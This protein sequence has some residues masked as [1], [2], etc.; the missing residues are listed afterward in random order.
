MAVLTTDRGGSA[1]IV[2]QHRE[3]ILKRRWKVAWL[4]RAFDAGDGTQVLI[5]SLDLM[6]GHV[7]KYWPRHDLE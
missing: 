3:R 2:V 1:A 4:G 7:V 5:D 6:V